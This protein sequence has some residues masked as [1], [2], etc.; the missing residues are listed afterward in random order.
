MASELIV[1]KVNFSYGRR[2]IIEDER[3]N[4]KAVEMMWIIGTKG[5]RKTNLMKI[6]TRLLVPDQGRILIDG[7]DIATW[8]PRTLA[9][10]MAV[11][12]QETQIS[13]EFSVRDIVEMG[14]SPYLRRF[15]AMSKQDR[16]I[17][18]AAMEAT[19]VL[20]LAERS[21]TCLL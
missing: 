15:Q 10:T 4:V 8:P 14:R 11:V 5:N 18:A 16:E 19:N 3:F 7:I 21:M 2:T 6:F 17:V 13:F 20:S 1:E 12:P 9:R